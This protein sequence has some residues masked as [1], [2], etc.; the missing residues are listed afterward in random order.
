[1]RLKDYETIR[2]N[3]HR[4][5]SA[6][7]FNLFLFIHFHLLIARGFN[8][9]YLAN[10]QLLVMFHW[11][12]WGCWRQSFFCVKRKREE[13][14]L[15]SISF[16]LFTKRAVKNNRSE[17]IVL[18]ERRRKKDPVNS[19]P[20]ACRSSTLIVVIVPSRLFYWV[21]CHLNAV[22]VGIISRGDGGEMML[23]LN[24]ESSWR[25]DCSLLNQ[26]GQRISS[27]TSGLRPNIYCQCNTM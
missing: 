8:C 27:E 9:F 12:V 4:G 24:N 1:M 26:D 7:F 14:F 25:A 3:S 22:I 11:S 23:C 19:L 17:S 16:F 13:Y 21:I 6:M 18:K 20:K 5:N 10:R 2:F 15:S